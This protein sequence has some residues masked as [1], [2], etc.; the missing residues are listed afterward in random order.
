MCPDITPV[1]H[2][3]CIASDSLHDCSYDSGTCHCAY[4]DPG[5]TWEARWTCTD[6]GAG[7]APN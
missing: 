4:V 3:P 1:E 2:Q 7:G 6:N 5:S